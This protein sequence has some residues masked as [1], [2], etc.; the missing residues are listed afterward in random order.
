MIRRAENI[1]RRTLQ[2]R[3]ISNLVRHGL[4]LDDAGEFIDRL[5]RS[6]EIQ[7]PAGMCMQKTKRS[8]GCRQ[9][10]IYR[11]LMCFFDWCGVHIERTSHPKCPSCG[12]ALVYLGLKRERETL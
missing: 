6:D 12:G 9:V 4:S 1:D 7:R 5:V 10:A 8:D 3:A 2:A 11:C